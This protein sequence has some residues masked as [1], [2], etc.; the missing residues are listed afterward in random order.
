MKP[1]VGISIKDFRRQQPSRRRLRAGDA[2]AEKEA[3]PA[4]RIF[5]GWPSGVNGVEAVSKLP[6]PLT[7]TLSPS[8]GRGRGFIGAFTRGSSVGMGRGDLAT[9]G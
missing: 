7:P 2:Q 9:P 8:D 1:D 3:F 5:V 6:K 4:R